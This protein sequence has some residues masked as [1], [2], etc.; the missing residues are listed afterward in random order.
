M[1]FGNSNTPV[2][3]YA[4]GNDNDKIYSYGKRMSVVLGTLDTDEGTRIVVNVNGKNYI[5][6]TDTSSKRLPA[7]GYWAIYNPS[8]GGGGMTFYPY[9]G[10]TAE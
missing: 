2:S 6:Y 1:I 5:D 4:V 3:G 7:Y 10:I 9:T 8:T